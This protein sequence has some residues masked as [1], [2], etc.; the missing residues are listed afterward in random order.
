M[1]RGEEKEYTSY[2]IGKYFDQNGAPVYDYPTAARRMAIYKGIGISRMV[3]EFTKILTPSFLSGLHGAEEG[4]EA[5]SI[6]RFFAT[7]TG[8][9]PY[10][11]DIRPG[12]LSEERLFRALDELYGEAIQE[13]MGIGYKLNVLPK[14]LP[15]DSE[16]EV[17]LRELGI[18]D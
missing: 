14:K 4:A 8:A 15:M 18:I 12:G 13:Q 6:E 17:F 9:K 3:S 10:G 1:V 5:T 7:M 2:Q 11:V 16:E